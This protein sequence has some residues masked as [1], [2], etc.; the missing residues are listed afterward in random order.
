MQEDIINLINQTHSECRLYGVILFTESHP[1]VVKALRDED[2]WNSLDQ[3]SGTHWVIFA[4]R[5]FKGALE[6]PKS[7]KDME[8]MQTI[9]KEPNTNR[10]LLQHFN[11]RDSSRPYFVV[12]ALDGDQL[13]YATHLIR[14][15][16]ADAVYQSLEE[17]IKTV[18]RELEN[19]RTAEPQEIYK[20]LNLQLRLLKAKDALKQAFQWAQS[21]RGATGI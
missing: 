15:K 18:S 3:M 14:G 4:T 1:Y 7:S 5:L 12:F 6:T 20:A 21:F 8:F 2:F 10:D 17:V 11:I 16:S 19:K 13:F 9:W